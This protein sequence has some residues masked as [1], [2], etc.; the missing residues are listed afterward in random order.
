MNNKGGRRNGVDKVVVARRLPLLA[1]AV[2]LA[3]GPSLAQDPATEPE[4]EETPRFVISGTLEVEAAAWDGDGGDGSDVTLAT[5]ELGFDAQVNQY[6]QAHLLFLYEEG[7]NDDDIAVDEATITIANQAVTPAFVSGGR[8]YV[9][10]GKFESNMISDPLTLEV[11][12]TQET[13]LQLGWQPEEGIYGS[14]FAFNGDTDDGGDDSIEHWGGNLG[15]LIGDEEQGL[16][17][18]VGYI[19]SLGDADGLGLEQVEAY[20]DGVDLYAVGHFGAFTLMAEYVAAL[21]DVNGPR[22]QVRA[23]ALEAGYRFPLAGKESTFSIGYQRTQEAEGFDLP[24]ER[25]LATLSVEVYDHTSV[26]VEWAREQGYDGGDDDIG[27][28]QLATGF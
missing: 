11:G 23:Y 13:A 28:L 24:E 9:P 22:S 3:S 20:A 27:T 12:E 10:F 25:T 14:I 15:L 7:E 6:T 8:M 17:L 1:A 18:G 16:D 21:D 26:A 4:K 5:A 2:L 19:N